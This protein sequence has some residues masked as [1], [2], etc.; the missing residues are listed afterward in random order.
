MGCEG[1]NENK[2]TYAIMLSDEQ[3]E[4]TCDSPPEQFMQ[5]IIG[6]AKVFGFDLRDLPMCVYVQSPE[7][8]VWNVIY[9]GKEVSGT[10]LFPLPPTKEPELEEDDYYRIGRKILIAYGQMRDKVTHLKNSKL[11]GDRKVQ[12]FICDL[13]E[14]M[15][16]I[17]RAVQGTDMWE[18]FN[19]RYVRNEKIDFCVI[20]LNLSAR[21]I[22]RRV[23][24][25]AVYIGRVL[26]STLKPRQL[27]E[28]THMADDKWNIKP[29]LRK[30]RLK[31][32]PRWGNPK[33]DD[34]VPPS[35]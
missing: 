27:Q 17:E 26:H 28:L 5:L 34:V 25:M 15:R 31:T 20:K 3:I 14:K 24:D 9:G 22:N 11:A 18:L 35:S 30:H 7:N 32:V 12:A 33:R 4:L 21:S 23:H 19:W 10:F 29:A 16:A 1:V 2:Y 8:G 13:E 6:F